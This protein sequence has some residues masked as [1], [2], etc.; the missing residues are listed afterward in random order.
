MDLSDPM[1]KFLVTD[2]QERC[3]MAGKSLA[4]FLD[5]LSHY[6][7][8]GSRGRLLARSYHRR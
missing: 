2:V 4:A 5:N 1:K 8:P 3:G 6:T 7:W